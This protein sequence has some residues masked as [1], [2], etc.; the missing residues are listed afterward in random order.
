[1]GLGRRTGVTE[2]QLGAAGLGGQGGGLWR[3]SAAHMHCLRLQ[4]MDPPPPSCSHSFL[5]PSYGVRC[6]HDNHLAEKSQP[7]SLSQTDYSFNDCDAL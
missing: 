4:G 7:Q 6:L 2:P 5:L 1:M 3:T